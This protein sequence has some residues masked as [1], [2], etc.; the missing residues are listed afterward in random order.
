[1][2]A[3]TVVLSGL[4]IVVLAFILFGLYSVDLVSLLQAAVLSYPIVRARWRG[5]RLVGAV[6]LVFYGVTTL[7]VAIE[8][9]YLPDALPPDLV[10][11]LLINGAITAA[12]FSPM[13]AL[14]HGRIKPEVESQRTNS[15]LIMPWSQWL[16]RLTLIAFG[17]AVL[18]VFFGALVYLPLARVLDPATLQ[19]SASP[20][21]P[22]WV[23]PFQMA[24]AL[25]WTALTLPVIRMMK[26]SWWETGFVT[27]LLFSVLMGSNL[28]MPTDMS[29]GLQLAHLIEVSGEAFMFGWIVVGLLH[30][31]H[32]SRHAKM[33]PSVTETA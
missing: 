4:R 1:M 3:R 16:W 12:V 10:L 2:R 22:S 28:L 29:K 25:L 23:L 21:L 8:G 18:F 15:R 19:A 31:R 13:A 5:W 24:R 11:H 6:F 20:D 14:I 9:I 33:I 30:H 26:G 27:A 7:L 32:K 17:W